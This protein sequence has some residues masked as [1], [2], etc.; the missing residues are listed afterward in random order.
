MKR[1]GRVHLFDSL[2]PKRTAFLVIDM[3]NT[4]VQPGSPAE[5]AASRGIVAG[6]NAFAAGLRP[7]GGK[8][9][10]ITTA[11]NHTRAGSEWD[12]FFDHFVSADVR[13]RTIEGLS[14]GHPGQKLWH[15]L[16]PETDDIHIVKNR[17]SAFTPGS[18]HLERVL[19]SLRIDNIL[20][21]GTKTNICCESTGRDAM[22]LD[23][24]AVM[25]SDCCAALSDREHLAT[26]ESFIQQFGDVM[27]SDEALAVLK[28]G[29]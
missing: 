1:R 3:Q 7:L 27:T 29:G 13:Q 10:W 14:P 6:I 20:I 11:V 22:M 21:G 15:E 8:V 12:N 23:F 18:S 26:L 9:V 25:V 2:D 4:F 16:K 28:K 19:R 24:K 17:Y 5:V